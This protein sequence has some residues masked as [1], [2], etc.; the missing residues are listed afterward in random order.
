MFKN[1]FCLSQPHINEQNRTIEWACVWAGDFFG[2]DP[3][4][5]FITKKW[6]P[7]NSS[8]Q[9]WIISCFPL[10]NIMFRCGLVVRIRG[11]HPRGP[12]SI[13]GSGSNILQNCNTYIT[14]N[15]WSVLSLHVQFL[16]RSIFSIICGNLSFY[17]RSI[18][19]ISFPEENTHDTTPF[20]P[21]LL[22][23]L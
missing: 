14:C 6:L 21:F 13:P 11:F 17:S 18:T 5:N 12:G 7:N 3:W 9:M 4:R 1:F 2:Y 16:F 8:A 20:P 22:R 10:W 23:D 19:E 15:T